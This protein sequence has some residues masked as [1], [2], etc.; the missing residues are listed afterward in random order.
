MENK[1]KNYLSDKYVLAGI[2]FLILQIII[3]YYLINEGRMTVLIWFC[4]HSPLLFSLAFFLKNKGMVKG[5]INFG[6]LIQIIWVIDFF[7]VTV[8]GNSLFGLTNYIFESEN[9]ASFFAPIVVHMFGVIVAFLFT[10]KEKPSK[11]D[12]VYSGVYILIIYFV[13]LFFTRP[14]L[15][16]NCVQ[17]FCAEELTFKYYNFLWPILSFA[18]I[19]LLTQGIR[20]LIW[21]NVQKNK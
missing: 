8:T 14:E 19:V 17:K 2:F 15:N 16:I 5:L 18:I 21:K 13:T 4:N 9:F 10:F 6:L 20:Y 1:I 3:T 7:N 12:L 11:K